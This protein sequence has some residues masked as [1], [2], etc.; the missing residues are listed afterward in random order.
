MTDEPSSAP[1]TDL[2]EQAPERVRV[3]LPLPLAE[4]YDY[5]VPPETH[6]EPG[7]IVEV[8]LGRRRLHGVVLGPADDTVPA[9]KLKAVI[10]RFPIDPLPNAV[11]EL[12]KWTASW[13]LAPMGSVVRLAMS[14]PAAFEPP[15]P[16][17]AFVR[18]PA[19]PDKEPRLTPARRRVLD[20]LEDGPPR[21]TTDIAVE[22]AV[23][24]GVVKGMLEAGLLVTVDLPSEPA[25]PKPDP[26]YEA[27]E[28]TSDQEAAA[29]SLRGAVSEPGFGVTLLDGV[30]GSGKTEVYLEAVAE[31]LKQGRQAL[32]LVPE[33]ALSTPWL[34]R[35]E[36][37]FGV[38]PAVWHSEIGPPRRRAVWRAV[39]EGRAR[40]VV[41]A[42]SALFLPFR[43]LGVIVVDEEHDAAYK[44]D[45]GV[46]Y[47]G[48]DMAIVRARIEDIP[49]VLATATPS[50]E[51]WTNVETGRFR[52]L[53]LP[54]RY[55]PARLPD[56][57]LVD[58]RRD[59][60]ERGRWLSNT[61]SRA[62]HATVERGEQALLFLNRRGYAPLTLCRACG[63]R[64][65]CPSCSAWLVEHRLSGRLQ[66]HHCGFSSRLPEKC[67]SCGAEDSL[68]ASGPGI[69]RV[70]E[71][72][73]ERFPDARVQTVSSDTLTGPAAAAEFVR[74]MTAGEIDILVGT[75]IVAKGYH[76]PGLTLVG[77]VDAD[78]G[79]SGGDLR[80]GER[81][82]QLLQQVAGRAGRSRK[83]GR[84]LLQTH[85]PD[86]PL[87]QAIAASDRD[88]F[89]NREADGRRLQGMPPFG[90]LAALI[91]SAKDADQADAVARALAR[92]AP[93]LEGVDIL[94]PAP[95]PLSL[96]RG[97][98]RRRL[99]LKAD[100]RANVQAILREWL[101]RVPI[102]GT[103]RLGI[104]VD[105]YSFM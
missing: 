77:V 38:T 92:S 30:T 10:R 55:G 90:R 59:R 71:E 48:R 88:G 8:P 81:T 70:A 7:A 6:L 15:K 25:I 13:T 51:T 84:V 104:D 14:V 4:P 2:F 11:V 23:G 79:L 87:M 98:H 20:L 36:A 39:S 62:V 18:N 101:S 53:E 75:Q 54:A 97:R 35:F 37:R 85:Q 29:A 96:L 32:V 56:I 3:L 74:A 67:P 105:P 61:L 91:V 95:A 33:I 43:E 103:V 17:R 45:D 27:P 49:I 41:G 26:D 12:V 66:C 100:R 102:P 16:I 44:Q 28:L 52:R 42:R 76:F 78:L 73:Y 40:V 69:E 82:F 50:L 64:I 31:A 86:D 99:L 9:D 5:A 93:R 24:A 21:T 72:V 94:G 57:D 46:S 58:L 68:V 63:H 60:P 89:L 19:A 80:A 34:E 65:E 83:P 47:H 1:G 22:A